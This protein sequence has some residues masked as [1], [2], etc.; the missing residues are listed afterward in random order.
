V[1]ASGNV[2]TERLAQLVR[3]PARIVLILALIVIVFGSLRP[4]SFASFANLRNIGMAAAILLVMAV[5]ATFVIVTAGVDLSVGAVLVFSGVIAAKT[6]AAAGGQGWGAAFLGL[7][8]YLVEGRPAALGVPGVCLVLML[9]N[10]PTLSGV[11]SAVEAL[12]FRLDEVRREE[13]N[14]LRR[15]GAARESPDGLS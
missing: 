13:W 9:V 12:R 14:K 7:V 15:A 3:G 6:M 2:W 5:G 10:F 8:A 4:E 11:A 1:S